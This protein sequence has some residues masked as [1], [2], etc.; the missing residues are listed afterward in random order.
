[1]RRTL[2]LIPLAA[3]GLALAACGSNPTLAPHPT[4]QQPAAHTK[5]QSSAPTTV[6]DTSSQFL[7]DYLAHQP[8]PGVP[9]TDSHQI[10][11]LGNDLCAALDGGETIG[12][13]KVKTVGWA[14]NTYPGQSGEVSG[15]MGAL[16]VYAVHDMCPQFMPQVRASAGN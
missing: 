12:Q 4:T 10:I 5:V 1:M 15:N 6:Q 2:L 11:S 16:M 3:A 7:S 8:H 14:T 9:P 13:Y